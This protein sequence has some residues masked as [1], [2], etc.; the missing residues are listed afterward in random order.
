M[1]KN[2]LRHFEYNK[3]VMETE[4]FLPADRFYI[5]RPTE[6]E[7]SENYGVTISSRF[8]NHAQGARNSERY[9][10]QSGNRTFRNYEQVTNNPLRERRFRNEDENDSKH[11][12]GFQKSATCS[13]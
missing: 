5:Q 1:W 11:R 12:K 3:L 2:L 9:V 7:E 13:S 8:Q 4:K 10:Q 6:S